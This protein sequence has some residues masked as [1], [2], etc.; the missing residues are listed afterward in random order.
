[1]SA[2]SPP[3]NPFTYLA[4]DAMTGRQLDPL[5]YVGVTFGELKNV[6]GPFAG[7]LP[8]AA[9]QT[10]RL[11]W[12]E[13]TAPGRVVTFID[14][15]GEI[16]WAG[17]QWR[18]DYDSSDPTRQLKLGGMTLQ[19]YFAL[20]RQVA[21]YAETWTSPD[22]TPATP[23]SVA[24]RL[25]TDTMA[26]ATILGGI[27]LQINIAGTDLSTVIQPSYPA[28][29]V[30]AVDSMFQTLAGMGF[31]EGFDYSFDGAY[32]PGTKTPAVT[33][34]LWYPRQGRTAAVSNIVIEN[35]NAIKFTYSQDS[36]QQGTRVTTTGS[37]T[38]AIIAEATAL[39]VLAAGW[40]LLDQDVSRT[41]ISDPVTLAN[42]A[43]A[44][45]NARCWPVSVMSIW[46][47]L[48]PTRPNQP[49]LRLNEFVLGDDLIYRIDPVVM[50][51]DGE[52]AWGE[53][54]DPRFP[55][56]MDFEWQII[57]WTVVPEGQ[58]AVGGGGGLPPY[59][60]LDCAIPPFDATGFAPPIPP[61]LVPTDTPIPLPPVP[62]PPTPP[63]PGPPT[64][65]GPVGPPVV[66]LGLPHRL[67][68]PGR[69]G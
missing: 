28:S 51:G 65:P 32:L 6:A 20:R 60:K 58:E 21:D 11:A 37:G 56:G 59:L 23:L 66:G 67:W 42:A 25:Y 8:L 29:S 55:D 33:C 38:G 17:I 16:V 34:N 27:P 2:W 26:Y 39:Q 18:N 54:N 12:Q 50:D 36:Q 49:F 46:L 48:Q 4:I 5:P 61:G 63:T 57:A 14:F 13:A 7:N 9:R 47:P 52:L 43:L 30:Q 69:R 19:S 62:G 41:Q 15:E 3:G 1:M 53:N 64:P 45:L 44:D 10:Q 22:G 40:P 68:M 35:A 31:T 24:E